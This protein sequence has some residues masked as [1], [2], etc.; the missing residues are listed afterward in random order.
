MH[1]SPT[2]IL[3]ICSGIFGVL[4]GGAAIV[5]RKGSERHRTAGNV[6]VISM[7]SLA[8]TGVY[9]AVVTHTPGNIFGGTLT[10]YLVAT[11]WATARRASPGIRMFDWVA[12]LVAF[13]IAAFAVTC[14][15]EAMK[16]PTGMK[17]EYPPGP[18]F[19]LGSRLRGFRTCACFCAAAFPGR[20]GSRGNFGACALRCSSPP[21]PSS[22]RGNTFSP[23]SCAGQGY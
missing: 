10:F 7:M 1:F 14:G 2:L 6:F 4:S 3:H 8:A 9:L 20:K 11:A 13:G 15:A 16:S 22:W 21:H 19:F 23:R 12:L 18:Y 5:F 17:D